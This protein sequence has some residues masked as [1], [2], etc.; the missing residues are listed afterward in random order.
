PEIAA[1]WQCDRVF[2]PT[3]SRDEAQN[4]MLSWEQ[5]VRQARTY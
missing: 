5:A 1:L 2:E 4:L 3:M